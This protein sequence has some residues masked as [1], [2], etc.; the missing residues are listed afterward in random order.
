MSNA[1]VKYT[2]RSFSAI[3]SAL[4]RGLNTQVPELTD[5]SPS[6]LLM[7]LSDMFAGVAEITNYYIDI[8][9]R[10]LFL[11]TARRLSSVIKLA[12]LANYNGKARTAAHTT[13]IFTAHNAAGDLI[14][15]PSDFTIP[16][17]SI[18]TDI[19]GNTWRTQT[20]QVFRETFSNT[21]VSIAQYSPVSN[22]NIGTSDGTVTQAFA[23][24]LTYMDSSLVVTISTVNW[25]LVETFGFSSPTDKHCIVK[26]LSD[27]AIYVVFGDGVKGA[28]PTAAADILIDYHSTQGPEGNTPKETITTITSTLTFP[29]VDHL[30][31]TNSNDG[32]GGR[33]TEGIEEL[34]RAIPI[35]LRTLGRAV[36]KKDYEDIAV[37]SANI[38]AARVEWDCGARVAIYLV[39]Y[40]GGNVSAAIL[41]ETLNFI[42]A[43]SLMTI[44]LSTHPSGETHI[45]GEVSI[46]GRFRALSSVITA[47]VKIALGELYSPYTA[48]INQDIRTSDIIAAIDNIP[49]VD[50][51]SLDSIYAQ[52][53]LRPSNPAVLLEYSMVVLPASS[54]A[55]LWTIQYDDAGDPSYPFV[56]SQEGTFRVRMAPSSTELSIG[57]LIDI[58]LG[59]TPGSIVQDDYWEFTVYPY[60]GDISLSDLTIPI[61]SPDDFT[62][63]VQQTYVTL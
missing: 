20:S 19:S 14:P 23:L 53:Y 34:R 37:L 52:P 35:S 61:I 48:N 8:T 10:E 45:H 36:T 42:K 43:R 21:Q 60:G 29:G 55:T 41:T 16:Q 49:E 28:I 40:G 44:D 12:E 50:Y 63:N 13:A 27:G 47:K 24:P 6:N 32:S 5:R 15:A 59:P 3:K 22:E 9:A 26:M 11:P 25:E 54:V 33:Y 4:L 30:E 56:V 62:I 17:G 57:G 58:T 46:V 31:V 2:D 51:L 18:L 38:R 39:S 7:V 1:W